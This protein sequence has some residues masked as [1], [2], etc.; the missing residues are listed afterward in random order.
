MGVCVGGAH[1]RNLRNRRLMRCSVPVGVGAL[2]DR[3]QAPNPDCVTDPASIAVRAGARTRA[4]A[5][6]PLTWAILIALAA[7]WPVVWSL[8]ASVPRPAPVLGTLPPFELTDETN[9]PFGSRELAGRVWVA[10]FVFTRCETV[11][12]RVTA[13]MARI[14]DRTRSL[15]PALHLVSFSVDPEYDTPARLADYA[16]A[17]RA[18][19]R[20][21]T[22]LTGPGDTVRRT[23]ER[24]LRV[25]VGRDPGDP[26]P[27]GI[28]HG[29]HLVLVDGAGR[30]RGYYDPDDPDAVERV[31]RD[32]ALLVNR[33]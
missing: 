9:R 31:V 24:G 16:R 6:R 2:T 29:A 20:M 19:P 8:R 23:V 7:A 26:S 33:G 28:S 32:A 11:C 3:P 4:L 22:F 12:P 27:A 13:Q 30:I 1:G 17:H 15:A 5:A 21:W 14:Q 18:S 25:S 10:S